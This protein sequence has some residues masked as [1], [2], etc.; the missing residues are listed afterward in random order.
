MINLAIIPLWEIYKNIKMKNLFILST[1]VLFVFAC[2]NADQFRAP[3][4]T[5][6]ADWA[7][8]ATMVGEATTEVNNTISGLTSMTDSMNV[9]PGTKLAANV[10]T[11]LDS[12]KILT[13]HK[14]K[15]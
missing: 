9:A 4:E 13:P 3:I 6:T 8:T 1:F 15:V 5:L 2:K 10:T 12:L 7:K 11:M 14:Y